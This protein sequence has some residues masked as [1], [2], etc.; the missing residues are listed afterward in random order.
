[1]GRYEG[2][3]RGT[4]RHGE[5]VKPLLRNTVRH[6]PKPAVTPGKELITR[7]SQVQ[8][9]PPLRT[10][11]L[12]SQGFSA[13]PVS[14]GSAVVSL[15]TASIPRADE[16]VLFRDLVHG[17]PSRP[18]T[19]VGDCRV[20][21]IAATF[22]VRC[23]PRIAHRRAAMGGSLIGES[24]ILVGTLLRLP[25]RVLRGPQGSWTPKPQVLRMGAE[26]G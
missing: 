13:F 11:N 1:M 17:V 23:R 25:A 7:R 3:L 8:I 18:G 9:P 10:K 21:I 24:L 26:T 2:S 5:S 6:R 22:G 4:A 20:S 14:L 12:A 19:G 16:F 15:H